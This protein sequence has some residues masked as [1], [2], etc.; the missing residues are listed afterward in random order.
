MEGSGRRR[1]LG[2]RRRLGIWIVTLALMG[3][4]GCAVLDERTPQELEAAYGPHP[5]QWEATFASPVVA[6]GDTWRLYLKAR[7]PDGDIQFIHI[8]IEM[9]SRTTT[10][11]RLAVEPEAG[12]LLSGY[13]FMNTMDFGAEMKDLVPGWIRVRL[14]LEDRGGHRAADAEFSLNFRFGARQEPPPP[15][16]FED[17]LLGMIPVEIAPV[18]PASPGRPVFRP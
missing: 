13:L 18:E 14:S 16:V 3:G 4:T 5:P 9:P 2:P 15:G 1:G 17:R 11:I 6:P 10:P 8:W 7:D 12:G